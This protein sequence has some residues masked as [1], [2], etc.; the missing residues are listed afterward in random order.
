MRETVINLIPRLIYADPRSKLET[1]QDA[2]DVA[3]QAVIDKVTRLRRNIIQ[4][5]TEYDN[6]VEENSWKYDLLDEGQREVGA[7]EWDPF[8]SK[9]KD[10]QRDQ[11]AEAAKNSWKNEQREQ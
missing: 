4:G 9:P 3:V 7:H 2:F 10:E 11:S 6:F 8:F 5:C 1:L